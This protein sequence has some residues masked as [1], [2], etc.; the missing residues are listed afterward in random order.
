M[1]EHPKGH[2]PHIPTSY[3]I[4]PPK[5]GEGDNTATAGHVFGPL[6][7]G[8]S[9]AMSTVWRLSYKAVH[10][11]LH[12]TKPFVMAANELNLENGKPVRVGG[13]GAVA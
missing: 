9:G 5:D 8:L 10:S 7:A 12:P 11:K 2:P 3:A 6:A 4:N 1:L 13:P